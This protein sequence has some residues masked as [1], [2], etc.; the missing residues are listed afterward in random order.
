MTSARV[1]VCTGKVYVD[2]VGSDQRAAARD[3]AIVRVEQLYP[4]PAQSLRA[5][6]DGYGSADEIVWVQ[7]EPENMGAWDFIRPA[8]RRGGRR[9]RGPRDRPPA[10]REPGRRIRGAPRAAAAAADRGG[11]R[12]RRQ[13]AGRAKPGTKPAPEQVA[14]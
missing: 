3:I 2:L 8:S 11:V 10:Q 9:T 13:A 14:G 12:A 6:L 5:M 4:V 1:I 7:E